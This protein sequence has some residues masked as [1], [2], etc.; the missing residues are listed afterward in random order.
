MLQALNK[1]KGRH[2]IRDPEADADG[3]APHIR[4]GVLSIGLSSPGQVQAGCQVGL[5][6]GVLGPPS[7][8]G[9]VDVG[10]QAELQVVAA[11]RTWHSSHAWEQVTG[12]TN[13][14]QRSCIQRTHGEHQAGPA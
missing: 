13:P 7:D 5:G 9:G 3:T 8:A 6:V 11:G 10:A 4:A 1:A 12:Q 14:R 2:G